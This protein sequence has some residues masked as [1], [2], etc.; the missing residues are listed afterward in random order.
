MTNR[1]YAFEP[2][3]LRDGS[4]ELSFKID[5]SFFAEFEHSLVTEGDISIQVEIAKIK[6]HL[7]L[8]LQIAGVLQLACDRCLE[9]YPHE[10][11]ATQ[12]LILAYESRQDFKNEEVI[13]IDEDQPWVDLSK[14]FY[15]FIHLEVPLRKVPAEDIHVCDETVLRLLGLVEDEE[16]EVPEENPEEEIDPR[17]EAL[18]KLK[19]DKNQ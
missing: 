16:E 4:N 18:K 3:K 5:R 9:L 8:I 13:M 17:W 15:D 6:T 19:F 10:I 14:E 11:Q 2:N 1:Q 12:R 7:D